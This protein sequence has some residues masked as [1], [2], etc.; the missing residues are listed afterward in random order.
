M[1]DWDHNALARKRAVMKQHSHLQFAFTVEDV[2]A[3][4]RTPMV[5][6]INTPPSMKR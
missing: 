3:M 4:G 5:Q 6:N 1:T 2:V